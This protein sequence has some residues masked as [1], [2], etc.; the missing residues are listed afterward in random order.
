MTWPATPIFSESVYNL[1]G[2]TFCINKIDF[3]A[4]TNLNWKYLVSISIS[5]LLFDM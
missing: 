1:D 4:L 5:H 3:F 2:N